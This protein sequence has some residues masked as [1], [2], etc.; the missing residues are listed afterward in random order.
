MVVVLR[1]EEGYYTAWIALEEA[2]WVWDWLGGVVLLVRAPMGSAVMG[3]DDVIVHLSLS[4]LGKGEEY[5]SL[6]SLA[7][8]MG[9]R[10]T[11][12]M[13]RQEFSYDIFAIK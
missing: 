2:V 8:G 1:W 9:E 6:E 10:A 3:R 11:L 12:S 7:L 13:Q 5:I 4:C